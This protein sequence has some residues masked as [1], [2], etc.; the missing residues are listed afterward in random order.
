MT[1]ETYKSVGAAGFGSALFSTV[2]NAGA[3][4]N[5][6]LIAS[7]SLV[8][9][10]PVPTLGSYGA[11]TLAL[12]LGCLLYVKLRNHHSILSVALVVGF[13]GTVVSTAVWIP[14][15]ISQTTTLTIEQDGALGCNDS[16]QLSDRI[17]NKLENKCPADVR[18]SY[19][20]ITDRCVDGALRC[21]DP[22][23]E[24]VS[25]GGIIAASETKSLLNVQCGGSL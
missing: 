23:E 21:D 2:A 9:N 12:L 1:L 11:V 19:T 3:L 13:T 6:P 10:E 8:N 7:W 16:Q 24:C 18:V 15:V 17:L 20:I 22:D 5:A 25:D 4:P 14:S